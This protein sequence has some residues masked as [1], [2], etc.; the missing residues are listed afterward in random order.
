MG[1]APY[2]LTKEGGGHSFK[3][4]SYLPFLAASTHSEAAEGI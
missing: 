4:N 1:R 2:M 3:R